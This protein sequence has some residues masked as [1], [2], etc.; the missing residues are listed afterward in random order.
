MNGKISVAV[1]DSYSL[2]LYAIS[3]QL[4]LSGFDVSIEAKDSEDFM[5]KIANSRSIPKV[6]ILDIDTPDIEEFATARDIKLKYP[7][8]KILAYTLFEREYSEVK[9]YG[10]DLFVK[11]N[12]S[13]EHIKSIICDLVGG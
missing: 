11:K 12:C 6:C 5:A 3:N 2:I 13:I 4:Q 8:I 10:I 1:V 7:E 9:S